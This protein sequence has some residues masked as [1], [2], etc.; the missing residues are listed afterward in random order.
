MSRLIKFQTEPTPPVGKRVR[1]ISQESSFLVE[2]PW[3]VVK[4]EHS[5]VEC[6]AGCYFDKRN[7]KGMRCPSGDDI[8]IDEKGVKYGTDSCLVGLIFA[9]EEEEQK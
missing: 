1:V 5:L 9:L 2:S 6:C 4:R 3:L 7:R 8:I